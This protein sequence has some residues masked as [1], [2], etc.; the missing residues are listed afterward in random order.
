MSGTD[1][2]SVVA[3]PTA[4]STADGPSASP[5]VRF[6]PAVRALWRSGDHLQ[7][8]LPGRAVVVEGLDPHV[9]TRLAD[10]G[11]VRPDEHPVLGLLH[12]NGFLARS[13]STIS[14]DAGAATTALASDRAALSARYGDDTD[15]VLGR[16]REC[17]VVLYG[18]GR[19]PTL[20]AALLAAAGVGHLDVRQPGEVTLRDAV[21]GGLRP[22]DEGRR[23]A[24]AAADAVHRAAP[25]VDTAP[26]GRCAD[27]VVVATGSPV[28]REMRALLKTEEAAHLVTGVWAGSAVVGPL[29]YPGRSSCLDCADRHRTDRDP[30]WPALAGQLGG[31]SSRRDPGEVA[32]CALAAALTA[33]QALAFLD[34]EEVATLGG[35]LEVLLPDWRVRRR[36]WPAH[37]DCGCTTVPDR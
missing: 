23:A 29:V 22:Q 33:I 6:A 5:T 35:T 34:G 26:L 31:R 1:D 32:L 2:P 8:E 24:V 14:Q 9:W 36:T 19:L 37:P 21:P 12:R 18:S 17:C 10:G 30:V 16:R 15:S 25:G 11:S 7:L 3:V 4:S 28:P 13:S 20:V 27:L